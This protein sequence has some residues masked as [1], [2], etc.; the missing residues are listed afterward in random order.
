[1]SETWKNF[2][3]GYSTTKRDN[4][5]AHT[6]EC[7]LTIELHTIA[8]NFHHYVKTALQQESKSFDYT[9]QNYLIV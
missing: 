4:K 5:C 8:F 6:G 2:Q 3:V 9:G 1:M 7:L